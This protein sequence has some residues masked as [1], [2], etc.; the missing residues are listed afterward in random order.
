MSNIIDPKTIGSPLDRVSRRDFIRGVIAG[1]A[2]VSSAGYLFRA[3]TLLGQTAG[4]AK[5]CLR[6]WDS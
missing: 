1:G 4:G 2:V 6:R 5:R 3:S